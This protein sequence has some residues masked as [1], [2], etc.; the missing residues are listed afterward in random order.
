[1][2]TARNRVIIDTIPVVS[3]AILIMNPPGRKMEA[4][5]RKKEDTDRALRGRKR[6]FLSRPDHKIVSPVII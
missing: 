6:F 2:R 1:M 5:V 3:R 4:E